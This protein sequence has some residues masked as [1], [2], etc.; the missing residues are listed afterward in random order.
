LRD[1]RTLRVFENRVP[2]RIFGL[3]WDEVKGE[4]EKLYKEELND[5]YCLPDIVWVI[6][7]G[8]MRLARHVA[9][10]EEGIGVYRVLV[11][12]LEETT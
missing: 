12:K 9:C 2:R 8:R 10:M 6:K 5:L 4:W 11:G 7:S 1:E 3:K